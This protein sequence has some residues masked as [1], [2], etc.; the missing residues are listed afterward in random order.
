LRSTINETE[1]EEHKIS[2]ELK[3]VFGKIITNAKAQ[4]RRAEEE[5][6]MM[7]EM[8]NLLTAAMWEEIMGY[9]EKGLK[10]APFLYGSDKDT[11]GRP[12]IKM[13]YAEVGFYGGAVIGSNVDL[14]TIVVYT[15]DVSIFTAVHLA[16]SNDPR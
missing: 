16:P 3:D 5:E 4:A 15:N 2:S 14:D 12:R 1:Q 6:D 13:T 8:K 7:A 10:V 9:V 11:R